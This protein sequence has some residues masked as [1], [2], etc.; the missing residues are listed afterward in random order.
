MKQKS[1][2]I[3]NRYPI[4]YMSITGTE[5]FKNILWSCVTMKIHFEAYL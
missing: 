2:K 3:L 5:Q 4:T 1:Y